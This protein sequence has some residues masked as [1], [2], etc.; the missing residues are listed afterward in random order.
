METTKWHL[1]KRDTTLFGK[2][3]GGGVGG[4]RRV[5]GRQLLIYVITAF[6]DACER[7]QGV[8]AFAQRLLLFVC[9][10]N[11]RSFCLWWCSL[12]FGKKEKTEKVLRCNWC[13][14][15]WTKFRNKH[16][17]LWQHVCINMPKMIVLQYAQPT[18]RHIYSIVRYMNIPSAHDVP[19]HT[20]TGIQYP[21]CTS[22]FLCI[23]VFAFLYRSISRIVWCR[24][25][26]L[27]LLYLFYLFNIVLWIKAQTSLKQLVVTGSALKDGCSHEACYSKYLYKGNRTN[28]NNQKLN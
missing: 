19:Q 9:F 24:V 15:I 18:K 3:G 8:Y 28:P 6:I 11:I 4:A 1:M 17:T 13:M 21:S 27:Y 5:R 16:I 22:V 10:F 26:R 25:Y 23:I 7:V 12:V 2:L 20:Y 14:K